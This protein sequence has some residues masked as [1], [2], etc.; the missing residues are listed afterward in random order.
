MELNQQAI[1]LNEI[2]KK[3][4]EKVY[5]LLSDKGKAIFF[6]K[7]GILGQSAEAKGK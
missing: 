1:E 7:K 6:P 4:N 5:E 3:N 2:I